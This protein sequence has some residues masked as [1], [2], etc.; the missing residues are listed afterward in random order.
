MFTYRMIPSAP[1]SVA[2]ALLLFCSAVVVQAQAP[3]PSE[4][5]KQ[6][7]E[8]IAKVRDEHSSPKLLWKDIS[9]LAAGYP[10]SHARF[11]DLYSQ[12]PPGR[13]QWLVVYQMA[14]FRMPG[15]EKL[16]ALVMENPDLR[17]RAQGIT[18][19]MATPAD[20]PELLPAIRKY[21]GEPDPECRSLL[22]RLIA[23]NPKLITAVG[24][25][26]IARFI[27]DAHP[28]VRQGFMANLINGVESDPIVVPLL[29]EA[30]LEPDP[31]TRMCAALGL[32]KLQVFSGATAARYAAEHTRL[33]RAFIGDLGS[34]DPKVGGAAMYALVTLFGDAE[35]TAVN[36]ALVTGNPMTRARAAGILEKKKVA[37]DPAP[38]LQVI[39]QGSEEAQLFACGVLFRFKQEADVPV[40]K[41]ALAS[42]H[43]S[44]RQAAIYA[45]E[46][47]EMSSARQVLIEALDHADSN[48][49]YRSAIVLGRQKV[50]AALPKLEAMA[51][52][53]ADA[54]L[55]N[56]AALAAAVAGEKDL[57]TALVDTKKFFTDAAMLPAGK[58]PPVAGRLTEV[59]DGVVLIGTQ[60]QLFV[61]DLVVENL[62]GA[63][64][65]LHQFKRDPRNPVLEEEVPW[66]PRGVLNFCGAVE[67][68][69]ATRVYTMWYASVGLPGGQPGMNVSFPEFRR[70]QL[71]AYSTDGVHWL[72]PDFHRAEFNGS[73]ANNMVG[74]TYNIVRLKNSPDPL[75]QYASYIYS[76]K[77]N[78]MA[79]S[80]SPDG[81]SGWTEF[82]RVVGGGNDVVTACRDDL[83]QGYLAFI[84][85][86]TGRWARRSATA[87][88]GTAPDNITD[89]STEIVAGFEDDRAAADGIAAAYPA[90]NAVDVASLNVQIYGITPFI[91]EGMYFGLP[92]RFIYSGWGPTG[93]GADGSVDIC[94]IAGRDKNGAG[95]WM[96]PASEA[97]VYYPP[98]AVPPGIH[99]DE[100][101][102]QAMHPVLRN[103][104]FGEWDSAQVYGCSVL[105]V[106][107]EFVLYYLGADWGHG[108]RTNERNKTLRGGI[109]RA[110][111]RLDG[112]VSLTAGDK[113]AIITTKTTAFAGA[114]LEV[115]VDCPKGSLAV[116]LL[117]ASGTPLLGF[118]RADA[119]AFTGDDLRRVVTWKGKNDLSAL[120]G[121]PIKFRF[122]L[123]HG[124]LYAFQ[125]VK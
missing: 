47:H 35:K 103:G 39:Q 52:E 99:T 17:A 85:S 100:R 93:E 123:K 12:V 69:P 73:K 14:R 108:H 105:V 48:I 122:Y 22:A 78:A 6:M 121:K 95:N 16:A 3:T 7:Q 56:S 89:G 9:D 119:D 25:E 40:L 58:A 115:N 65:V 49:R 28:I 61:D 44:V 34:D 91:Y 92:Q 15:G 1:Q 101:M 107:D 32:S 8:L 29:L 57:S 113:E 112:F 71:I 110:T 120:A 4:R 70:A 55:R 94:L 76:G 97:P 51:A 81:I 31:M 26:E 63:K 19:L 82:K 116:E 2:L 24:P 42:Q 90:V 21:L 60:K 23:R 74:S 20:S 72:R 84:K 53:D 80:F 36:E 98:P 75:R 5:E 66:E 37:F 117:D 106:D 67:Y 46:A 41:A 43:A 45:L 50:Q 86:Q 114:R 87:K 118:S 111:M 109:W 88:W 83:G 10:E 59:K 62:S 27:K 102:V 33:I 104:R 79:V 18:T 30:V 38:L 13:A 124:D 54:H 68:D 77:L 64:R 11:V 96:R 125:S